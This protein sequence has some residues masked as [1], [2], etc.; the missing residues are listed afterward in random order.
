MN[1]QSVYG[2]YITL[3]SK[4]GDDAGVSWRILGP[5]EDPAP[6]TVDAIKAADL[7]S[8]GMA[9]LDAAD[10][11]GPDAVDD[12]S[13]PPSLQ[14]DTTKAPPLSEEESDV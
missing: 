14:P 7:L 2:R 13:L 11:H 1:D 9:T 5:S 12:F 4:M 10:G 3:G 8:R 6:G